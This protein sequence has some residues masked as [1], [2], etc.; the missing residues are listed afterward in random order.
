[1]SFPQIRCRPVLIFLRTKR[2]SKIS[3]WCHKLADYFSLTFA[4]A[5]SDTPPL[6]LVSLSL[7][8]RALS[9]SLVAHALVALSLARSPDPRR[10]FLHNAVI[11]NIISDS[12]RVR[13][14]LWRGPW[15]RLQLRHHRHHHQ[16]RCHLRARTHRYRRPRLVP[17]DVCRPAATVIVIVIIAPPP[18]SIWCCRRWQWLA[19]L[20]AEPTGA[21]LLRR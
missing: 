3:V 14:C 1:M 2:D 21:P 12:P 10:A 5:S 11:A 20:G 16:P 8:R 13:S 6:S 15:R 19:H 7:S 4:A 18:P 9:P 17:E